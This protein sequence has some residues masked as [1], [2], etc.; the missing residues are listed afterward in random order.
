[1]AD[2]IKIIGDINE[3]ERIS[4]FDGKDIRLLN[5]SDITQYFG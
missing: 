1:M 2:N 4:R 3:T 5:L